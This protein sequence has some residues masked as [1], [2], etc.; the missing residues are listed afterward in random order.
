MKLYMRQRRC[1]SPYR[2]TIQNP[3]QLCKTLAFL[4]LWKRRGKLYSCAKRWRFCPYGKDEGN[5]T[6]VQNVGV[7]V[8]MEKTREALQLYK[9]LAFLSLWKR[10]G[11]LYGCTEQSCLC[12]YPFLPLCTG[13]KCFFHLSSGIR[14][15]FRRTH[16]LSSK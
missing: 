15:G 4:S 5:S 1:L 14:S 6:A 7:S 2:E 16:V 10:R 11:K 12:S 3:L 8:P 13:T 9:T